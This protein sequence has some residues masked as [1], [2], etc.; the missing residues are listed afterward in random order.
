V[1]TYDRKPEM[2]APEVAARFAAEIGDG[3]RFGIVNFANPDMVGHTGSIPA[4]VAAVETT[5]RCLGRVLE[6][7]EKAGG[8]ALVTADHGNAETM[9]AEDGVSPHTAHTTNPVPVI[10]TLPG[11]T[12]REG[13]GLS[14]LAPTCLDLLGITK[15]PEMTGT[16]LV[17]SRA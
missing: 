12:L 13:G 9:L 5:D 14:D 17:S 2:S 11:G 7:I 6:A 16:S 8:V 15:P 10:V 1:G 4:A 3:Y